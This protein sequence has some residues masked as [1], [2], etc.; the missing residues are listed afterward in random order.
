MRTLNLEEFEEQFDRLTLKVQYAKP[1]DTTIL[2]DQ[3][4]FFLHEQSI[5]KTI[6]KRIELDFEQIRLSVENLPINP[7]YN[8]SK[9]ILA[10]IMSDEIQGAFS[11]F[12]LN[13]LYQSK[14]RRHDTYYIEQ[15]HVWYD[16]GSDYHEWQDKFN[17]YFLTPLIDIFKWYCYESKPK[18]D[19]DYFSLETRSEVNERLDEILIKLDEQGFANEIIFNEIEELSDTLIFLNKRSWLQLMQTKLSPVAATMVPSEMVDELRR[20]LTEFVSNLPNTPF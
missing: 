12:Q 4:F 3:L 5:S 15:S 1:E 17:T 11:L 14:E 7:T 2:I 10:Q 20:A 18:Y 9:V 16:G 6:F 19:R 8:E 13:K